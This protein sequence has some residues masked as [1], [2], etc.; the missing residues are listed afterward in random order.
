[1]PSEKKPLSARNPMRLF[2]FMVGFAAL[3]LGAIGVV[4]PLLPTTPFIIL[5]AFAFGKSS[6]RLEAWLENSATFGPMIAN[7]RAHGAIAMRY[8]LIALGMMGGAFVISV[9]LQMSARVLIIQAVCLAAAAT[10]ILT[11]PS[12]PEET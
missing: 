2:W 7:W 10:F 11:R 9:L 12:G 3:V 6:P 5:A 1:M 8:K 4:L